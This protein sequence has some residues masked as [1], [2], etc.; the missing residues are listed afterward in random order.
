M[1][2]R[3]KLSDA[4]ARD[5]ADRLELS[6]PLPPAPSGNFMGDGACR[7]ADPDI[8]VPDTDAADYGV[9]VA[10]AKDICSACPVRRTCQLC[11]IYN[12]GRG[13]YGG[14]D[15][16]QRA[17]L[18]KLLAPSLRPADPPMPAASRSSLFPCG[19]P[20][21][22]RRH[23]RHNEPVCERCQE[24]KRKDSAAARRRADASLPRKVAAVAAGRRRSRR[25]A[26]TASLE[27]AQLSLL[28]ADASTRRAG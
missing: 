9:V 13:V 8:M 11:G 2:A 7:G 16:Y 1:T 18:R 12:P 3:R 25:P 28:D 19:T 5:L 10:I 20:A 14:L 26:K 23:L 4:E 6:S 17:S 15:D 22:Y 24:A 21:A 27:A